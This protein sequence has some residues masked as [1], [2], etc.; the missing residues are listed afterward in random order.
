MRKTS[1][2]SDAVASQYSVSVAISCGSGGA[3]GPA[4]GEAAAGAAMGAAGA[5]LRGGR[6]HAIRSSSPTPAQV[7]RT[8][9]PLSTI[10]NLKNFQ[11]S[12]CDSI[13]AGRVPG[14]G[15]QWHD[16]GAGCDA[17]AVRARLTEEAA[18]RRGGSMLRARDCHGQA[19]GRH[20]WAGFAR[21]CRL[22]GRLEP[23][24]LRIRASS[25]TA[26]GVQQSVMTTYVSI[27]FPGRGASIGRLLALVIWIENMSHVSKSV[28]YVYSS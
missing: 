15:G 6:S 11:N 26:L 19:H 22:R 13:R 20:V 8:S 12:G 24:C 2:K 10:P 14:A 17:R 23:A 16:A 3:A 5:G 25:L 9:R 27:V 4:A 28:K 7:I 1:S 21:E 18:R